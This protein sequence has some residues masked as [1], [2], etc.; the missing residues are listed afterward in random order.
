M[1]V[2]MHDHKQLIDE[3]LGSVR[4]I[5]PDADAYTMKLLSEVVISAY[6]NGFERGR[7]YEHE[8]NSKALDDA[9]NQIAKKYQ[10]DT[11]R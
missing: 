6:T 5:V 3:V 9:L 10:K 2:T 4:G 8:I 7:G 1:C 11:E